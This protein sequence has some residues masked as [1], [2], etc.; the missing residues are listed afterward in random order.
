MGVWVTAAD[1]P[2][3]ARGTAPFEALLAR[4]VAC[5]AAEGELLAAARY[6]L[7]LRSALA[8]SLAG[9]GDGGEQSDAG[10]TAASSLWMSN[11]GD[12]GGGSGLAATLGDCDEAARALVQAAMRGAASPRSVASSDASNSFAGES[13]AEAAEEEQQ[14]EQHEEQACGAPRDADDDELLGS[15]S[16]GSIASNS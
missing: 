6:A 9:R 1:P 2:G 16:S 14:L 3:A 10:E 7:R 13:G 11:D 12:G 4:L 5:G 8:A 15:S